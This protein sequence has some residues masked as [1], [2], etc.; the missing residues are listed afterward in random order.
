MITKRIFST[1]ISAQ[2]SWN[3]SSN[4][5]IHNNCKLPH[6]QYL[7]FTQRHWHTGAGQISAVCV[8]D[9]GAK[10]VVP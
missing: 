7:Q 5:F 6:T 2:P 8:H 10:V 4:L 3:K 9:G 1:A